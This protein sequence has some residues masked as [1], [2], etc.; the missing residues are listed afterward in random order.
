[1]NIV[2]C[3]NRERIR[4]DAPCPPA[5]HVLRS[6]RHMD[7][8]VLERP[9][10]LPAASRLDERRRPD[11]RFHQDARRPRRRRPADAVACVLPLCCASRSGRTTLRLNV[12]W[13]RRIQL[14]I[15]F[16]HR[17]RHLEAP[18]LPKCH[19]KKRASIY[20]R[21]EERKQGGWYR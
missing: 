8:T 12:G 15:L 5:V 1:M 11:P 19:T 13:T 4:A 17:Q 9:F 7:E 21:A 14:L 10:A 16:R 20:A 3:A 18:T 6:M 2:L